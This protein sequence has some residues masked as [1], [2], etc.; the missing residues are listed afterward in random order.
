M[1]QNVCYNN[2]AIMERS[3]RL[4]ARQWLWFA[5]LLTAVLLANWWTMLFSGDGADINAFRRAVRPLSLSD[6]P[7]LLSPY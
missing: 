3:R 4:N 2:N 5:G 1:L 7:E 6:I